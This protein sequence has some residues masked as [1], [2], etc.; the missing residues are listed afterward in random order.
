MS[1][2]EKMKKTGFK[3]VTKRTNDLKK[4][5][6]N[7]FGSMAQTSVHAF[8]IAISGSTKGGVGGGIVTIA[9][10]S[11]HFKTLFCLLAASA[12]M[13]KHKDAI[14]LFYDSEG[15]ANLSYFEMMGIDTDRVL[16]IPVENLEELKFDMVQKLNDLTE[17]EH[18]FILLDSAGNLAS[19]KE[20][21]DA[22]DE[23]SVA[24]MTRAKAFKSFY[25]MVT[26][27]LKRLKIPFF[28]VQHTYDTMENYSKETVGGGCVDGETLIITKN[29]LVEMQHINVGDFVLSHDDTWKEVECVWN[30]DTLI[31]GEPECFEVEFEDGSVV[32]CSY[33]HKFLLNGKWVKCSE[34]NVDDDVS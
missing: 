22:M 29:G 28:Q 33:K 14:C 13:E 1:L 18:V 15:G 9:G 27:I 7:I 5:V 16:H 32:T 31:E 19:K 25:R 6:D 4:A 26:P 10:K 24:D 12:Y 8:N 23:K 34:L 30:P 3:D 2:M 20:L 17:D 11:K 21:E